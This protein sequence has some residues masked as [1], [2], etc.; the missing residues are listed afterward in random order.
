[1]RG[2]IFLVPLFFYFL[3]RGTKQL[4]RLSIASINSDLFFLPLPNRFIAIGGVVFLVF[5]TGWMIVTY[6]QKKSHFYEMVF[7]QSLL[8]ASVAS[9]TQDR[10][11][12]GGV[13]D[14]IPLAIAYANL[15]DLGICIAVLGILIVL[16]A[17]RASYVRSKFL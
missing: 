15:A 9:N 11:Q 3:D 16:H 17:S 13:I 4:L 2:L 12:Y 14:W 10:F 6:I 5:L 1:M 8:F 7:F